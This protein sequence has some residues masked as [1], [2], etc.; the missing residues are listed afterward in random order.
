MATDNA[1]THQRGALGGP[2]AHGGPQREPEPGAK[3]PPNGHRPHRAA[4][5]VPHRGAVVAPDQR[6]HGL[7]LAGAHDA[8]PEREPEREPQRAPQRAPHGGAKLR[9]NGRADD[10]SA[11]AAA[12][13]LAERVAEPAPDSVADAIAHVARA[14]R[15]ADDPRADPSADRGALGAPDAVADALERL[16]G[17][18]AL[19]AAGLQG[20]LLPGPVRPLPGV[21]QQHGGA[22]DAQ[23]DPEPEHVPDV[24]DPVAVAVAHRATDGAADANGGAD[25][26]QRVRQPSTVQRAGMGARFLLL[27]VREWVFLQLLRQ[28]R[29]ADAAADQDAD[30]VAE[31]HSFRG[32]DHVGPDGGHGRTH[33]G[34][35]SDDAGAIG[36]ADAGSVGRAVLEP[37]RTANVEPK[38]GPDGVPERQPVAPRPLRPGL[39]PCG[40]RV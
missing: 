36:G 14:D 35:P 27:P 31:P 26:L 25:R 24:A 23:A 9:A 15:G 2:H 5:G 10:A 19:R 21:L 6:P 13:R 8:A 33:A 37:Q 12:V 28:H 1:R 18:P 30:G 40:G 29:D 34:R 17:A 16:R 11:D 3:R 39:P 20:A 7:A 32:T 4:V 22:D 38:P